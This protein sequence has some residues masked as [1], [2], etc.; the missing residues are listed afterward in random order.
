M[1][2]TATAVDGRTERVPPDMEGVTFQQADIRDVDLSEYDVILCLGLFYHL[3]AEDQVALLKRCP[4]GAVVIV[5]TQVWLEDLPGLGNFLG[6]RI[7]EFYTGVM[8]RY[9]GIYFKEQATAMA[10]I[11]NPE[12]FFPTEASLLRMFEDT[13]FQSVM[14][15]DP[16]YY[17]PAG[18]RRWY[19]GRK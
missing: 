6:D 4:E 1:G 13:G 9:E 12:S 19:V 2:H 11:G 7:S 10:S 5:D 3:E 16:A 17:T 18:G 8:D 15:V 14:L